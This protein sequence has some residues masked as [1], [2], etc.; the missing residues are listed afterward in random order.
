MYTEKLYLDQLPPTLLDHYLAKGWYR[1]GQSM[2]TCRFLMFQGQLFPAVWVRLP[3]VQYTFNKRLR[4]IY[5]RN[6]GRFKV[7]TQPGKI[8]MEKER[9]YQR[10]RNDFQGRLAPSLKVSLLDDG[11]A[12]LFNTY[13]TCIYDGNVLVGFSFFDLGKESLASIMGVYHPDYKKYSLGFFTMLLEISFAIENGFTHYYP[14]YIVPGYPKFDYK[15]RI[16]PVECFS[17]K[18]Q[19]W[20]PMQAYPFHD[21]PTHRMEKRL[22]EVKEYLDQWGLS[23]QLVLYPPYEANL[24]GYWILDYLEYP[25]LLECVQSET[26]SL[27]TVVIFD[28]TRDI[29]RLYLCSVYDD[30]SDFFHAN[31]PDIDTRIPLLLELLIKEELLSEADTGIEMAHTIARLLANTR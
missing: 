21:L 19:Q 16:G 6:A 10:Y 9:L 2:F 20:I 22:L 15:T 5:T 17:E 12:N 4:K 1:M 11:H 24:I 30:L 27:R 31:L 13:E 29:Y 14:G 23:C 8:N 26:D 3:L 25:I 7:V 18:T 28:A